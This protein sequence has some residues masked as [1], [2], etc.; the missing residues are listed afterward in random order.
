MMNVLNAMKKWV[1]NDSHETFTDHADS[2]RIDWLRVVPF[3]L[4]NLSCL[5]VFYVGF[6][7]TALIT[8]IALVALRVFA[9]TGFYHRYF[10]HKTY[11]TNRF[12]Q[13]V[14]ATIGA[15]AAQR[16]PLWWASH[17]RQHHMVS[18]K[19]D[20]AHS[21]LQH[22]FWWSHFGWFLSRKNYY[23]NPN[24][25]KD[26]MRY[27]ELVFLDKHDSLAPVLLFIILM[28]SGFLLHAFAPQ[29]HTTA[30]KMLV[31]GF[32]ISTIITFH[33]TSSINSL[34]HVFGTKRFITKDNSRNNFF[35]ALLTFGEGWHNN[36]H[37]YPATMRQGFM[38][39]EIDITYYLLKG[40]EKIGIIWDVKEL[41][42]SVLEKNRVL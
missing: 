33:L 16:G 39:W 14:F 7:W 29:L 36:H 26:L 18:D 31:W 4:L 22:G 1:V 21:P 34:T 11:Q 37:H 41:P 15:S 30:G 38:W 2:N 3:V 8:A 28:I 40:L 13:F 27:P 23:F 17:H 5:L 32:S 42:K 25:V 35:L 24:R 12:W 9:L 20:D 6:S 19:F 10:S